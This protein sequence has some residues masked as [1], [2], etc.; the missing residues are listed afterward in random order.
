MMTDAWVPMS[1]RGKDKEAG[2]SVLFE[3]VP[4]HLAP[5]LLSEVGQQLAFFP[6]L[7]AIVQRRLR[8]THLARGDVSLR[9]KILSAASG[10]GEL[11]LDV[12]D[13]LLD[14]AR[15]EYERARERANRDRVALATAERAAHFM[16]GLRE[17]LEEANSAYEVRISDEE[18]VL[19]RRVDGTATAAARTAFSSGTPASRLLADAWQGTFR[20]EPDLQASYRSAVLAVES[21]ATAAFTPK[22]PSPSLGKAI[23]HLRDTQAKWTVADLDDQSQPAAATLLALLETI[24]QNHQRHVA[25]GGHPP[26]PVEQAEA[27]AVLFGAITVVQ[28][29]ERGYVRGRLGR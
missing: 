24:W 28:W 15:R 1:M 21:V 26:A 11:L 16:A 14:H 9:D 19:Q 13:C 23:T 8:L 29:F 10:D 4:P 3:G 18:W 6:Q 7:P 22:D 27:E 12:A 25:Q 2:W 20:R 5:S 17:C